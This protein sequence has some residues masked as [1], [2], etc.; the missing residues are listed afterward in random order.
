MPE[1]GW[2]EVSRR[3]I[4]VCEFLAKRWY[5]AALGAGASLSKYGYDGPQFPLTRQGIITECAAAKGMN[6][7]WEG[8]GT[9]YRHDNDVGG[10][11]VRGTPRLD[12]HLIVRPGDDMEHLD[13]PWVLVLG[14][15]S[16]RRGAPGSEH[17]RLA[18]WVYGREAVREEWVRSP[19]GRPPAY[20]APQHALHEM[21]TLP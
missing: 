10:V 11:Q 14:P 5:E 12:G 1:L 3:E 7:Y 2:V 20:F 21:T 16:G 4:E 13:K 15:V 19:N 18:G 17:Y 8:I 6:R 9:D